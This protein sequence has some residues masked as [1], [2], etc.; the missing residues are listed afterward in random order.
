MAIGAQ[1][2][3]EAQVHGTRELRLPEEVLEALREQ[4]P[5]RLTVCEPTNVSG[6]KKE[7]A[8]EPLASGS[9]GRDRA[10]RK[11]GDVNGVVNKSSEDRAGEVFAAGGLKGP[12]TSTTI[13]FL[14]R[15]TDAAA[16]TVLLNEHP[17]PRLTAPTN[18]DFRLT[19]VCWPISDQREKT[20]EALD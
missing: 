5:I 7:V 14:R 3:A 11:L 16:S 17:C 10:H 13:S 18:A 1:T 20:F 4:S 12:E 6:D 2:P 19:L 8:L 15:L 9:A